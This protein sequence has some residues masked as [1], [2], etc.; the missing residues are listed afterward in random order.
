MQR[1]LDA[2]LKITEERLRDIHINA[3]AAD[4]GDLVE[5][6][7]RSTAGVEEIADINIAC[8]DDAVERR[9]DLFEAGQLLEPVDR[10][11]AGPSH[12]L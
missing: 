12:S 2:G 11:P 1:R 4:G 5:G 7:S 6:S 9:L 8:R 3:Y 10:E